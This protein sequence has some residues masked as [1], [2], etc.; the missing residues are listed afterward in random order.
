MNTAGAAVMFAISACHVANTLALNHVTKVP[1]VSVKFESQPAVTVD[2]S[3]KTYSAVTKM[4]SETVA[5]QLR[6]PMVLE[7]LKN[8]SESSIVPMFVGAASIAEN[9]PAKNH[10]IGKMLRR[11]TAHVHQRPFHIARAGKRH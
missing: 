1:V 6:P 5:G 7:S 4:S 11:L 9:I 2:R 8:G 10:A 3:R